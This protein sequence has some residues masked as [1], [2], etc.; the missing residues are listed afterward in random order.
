MRQSKKLLILPKNNVNN[1]AYDLAGG[2]YKRKRY[3]DEEVFNRGIKVSA[4]GVWF[5]E[6]I[7]TKRIQTDSLSF[8]HHEANAIREMFAKRPSDI[9]PVVSF[10]SKSL[11]EYKNGYEHKES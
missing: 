11:S 6:M 8:M 7:Q 5:A 4:N 10:S 2:L 9:S 1:I 3:Y